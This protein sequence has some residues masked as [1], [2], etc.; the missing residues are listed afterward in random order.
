MERAGLCGLAQSTQHTDWPSHSFLSEQHAKETKWTPLCHTQWGYKGC[1]AIFFFREKKKKW[2]LIWNPWKEV[3][4]T[5]VIL[6]AKIILK[7]HTKNGIEQKEDNDKTWIPT[8]LLLDVQ[9]RIWMLQ[10]VGENSFRRKPSGV[11]GQKGAIQRT[12]TA[13]GQLGWSQTRPRDQKGNATINFE[14]EAQICSNC[15]LIAHPA[16]RQSQDISLWDHLR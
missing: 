6:L 12:D 3:T 2:N 9:K 14:W 13:K 8:I 7:A 4:F 10:S 16:A 15:Y 5:L 1:D 11:W